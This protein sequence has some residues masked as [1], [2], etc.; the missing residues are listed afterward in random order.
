MADKKHTY[1]DSDIKKV[2]PEH[3]YIHIKLHQEIDEIVF[4]LSDLNHMIELIKA[5]RKKDA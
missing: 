4:S 3:N 5:R 1:E 2:I